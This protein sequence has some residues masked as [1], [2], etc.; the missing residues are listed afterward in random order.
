MGKFKV[1]RLAWRA[2]GRAPGGSDDLFCCKSDEERER[3]CDL[4]ETDSDWVGESTV[5]VWDASGGGPWASRSPVPGELSMMDQPAR[6]NSKRVEDYGGKRNIGPRP[7]DMYRERKER[8]RLKEEKR[9]TG[10]VWKSPSPESPQAG[11][12]ARKSLPRV[13]QGLNLYVVPPI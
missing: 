2:V 1:K 3:L 4:S 6:R 7:P 10:E 8:L 5:E 13:F 12:L 11:P 9:L